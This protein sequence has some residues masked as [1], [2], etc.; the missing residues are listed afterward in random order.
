[1]GPVLAVDSGIFSFTPLTTTESPPT[2]VPLTIPWSPTSRFQASR[3]PTRST[4]GRFRLWI[5]SV[6]KIARTRLEVGGVS[7]VDVAS[8][9]T[10]KSN[11]ARFTKSARSEDGETTSA[12]SMVEEVV[13]IQEIW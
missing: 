2:A 12:D 11:L 8:Y 9:M 1:M 7:A 4:G 13:L 6:S 5:N 3:P 10:T